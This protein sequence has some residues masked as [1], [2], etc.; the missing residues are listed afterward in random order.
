MAPELPQRDA[1]RAHS[2][3]AASDTLGVM[4]ETTQ[5][6]PHCGTTAVGGARFCMHCGGPVGVASSRPSAS[7]SSPFELLRDELV[8]ATAGEYRVLSELGRGGMAAVYLAEDLSLGRRVAVKVMV[9]GLDAT[10]GMADRFLLEARTAAQLSHPNI[11]PIYA[12]RTTEALRYFVMKFIGGRSLDR[13]LAETGPLP[14]PV[15]LA[16]LAQVG[17]ALE[18]AHRRG[19]VHRD[20]KPANIML[21]EDGAAIVADFGIAKVAQG[22]SLTQTGSTVGTPTYMSPE[23]CTGKVVTG[24]SD[25][26]ALGCVAFELLTGRP[27]FVHQEV[28]PVLLAHVSDPPPPLLPLRT[29]CPLELAV[30]IDKMLAKDPAER[31]ASLDE[32]ITAA[33]AAPFGAD[34]WVRATMRE[35]GGAGEQRALPPM[36]SIPVSPLP[37]PR[38]RTE[39]MLSAPRAQV[40]G[41]ALTVSIQPNGALLQA[42]SGLQLQAIARDRAGLPLSEAA[43]TWQSQAPGVVRVSESGVVTALAEGEAEIVAS[44]DGARASIQVRVAR[45]PVSILRITA[46]STLWQV[47]DRAT[48]QAVAFDQGG[49][50]L[51]G[52]VIR[53]STLDPSV[54]TVDSDGAVLAL[55]EGQARIQAESEGQVA[56]TALEIRGL[57]GYLQ[58]LPG[59]GALAVGQVVKLVA[60]WRTG[61]GEG[62]PATN[63]TWSS[64]DPTVLRVTPQGEL[65]GFRPGSAQIRAAFA[66]QVCDV[67]YQVSRVEVAAV[68]ITPRPTVVEVGEVIRLQ[69]QAS[70]R[71]GSTLAGRVV[72][73]TSTHPD[74]IAVAPDGTL[75]GISPGQARVSAS[76]GTGFTG[77]DVRVAPVNVV[78]VR[79]EPSALTLRVGE[80]GELK[81]LVQGHKSGPL[82]GVR[83]EWQSSD[84]NVAQVTPEGVVVGV[85]FGTARIAATAGGRRATVAVEVRAAATISAPRLRVGG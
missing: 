26:Y 22:V 6:C 30:V 46:T 8:A 43:I 7:M 11:I 68:R 64:S 58:V 82:R 59:E 3:A 69:A 81:A 45:V 27:P 29:D 54:A 16:I 19:V 70:D 62:K 42:G 18:H 2:P 34:P 78:A 12:V 28:V 65:T 79:L 9:P 35:L 41:Q 49:S 31:W 20:I 75:R 55:T 1:G 5:T 71:L 14:V 4:T 61:T 80:S 74:I 23:Q 60:V 13:V 15:V 51:P 56:E 24:A 50:V 32:A 33:E 76:V 21:D 47:G 36:P 37:R 38:P 25:Q 72:T 52:R 17:S 63:A 57:A 40:G 67:T 84:P 39:P 85:R 53:W 77:F 48:L 10:E 73:W 44:V 66:G 83:V